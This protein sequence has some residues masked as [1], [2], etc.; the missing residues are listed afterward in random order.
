MS[1]DG[2]I[3]INSL[4]PP[5][6]GAARG[7]DV[8]G[9][10]VRSRD[11]H[12][13]LSAAVTLQLGKGM[14][15]H[16][17]MMADAAWI[18][19]VRA[20]LAGHHYS[21]QDNVS[22]ATVQ[23]RSVVLDNRS[24]FTEDHNLLTVGEDCIDPFQL[25][26]WQTAE[27]LSDAYF[28]SLHGTFR[29]V[30]YENYLQDLRKLYEKTSVTIA[31]LWHLRPFLALSNVMWATGARWLQLLNLEPQVNSLM[32]NL[33]LEGHLSYYARARALGLDHR[34]QIDHPSM[35]SIQGMAVLALYLLQNGSINR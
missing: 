32:G 25:P 18:H 23:L 1:L 7:E 4:K 12:R 28:R 27:M 6:V 20:H 3:P 8:P 29:F 16:I 14:P 17:G 34:V 31:S 24:Y 33:V 9:T 5:T 2:E 26:P 19:S 30:D 35:E 22:L 11:R 21:T 13:E 10:E 15:G